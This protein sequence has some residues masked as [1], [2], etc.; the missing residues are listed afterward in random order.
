[1]YMY[2]NKKSKIIKKNQTK[3]KKIGEIKRIKVPMT[4]TK[5]LLINKMMTELLRRTLKQIE[6]VITKKLKHTQISP[7]A[8]EIEVVVKSVVLVALQNLN[9]PSFQ[10]MNYH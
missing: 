2:I 1:M 8:L 9:L 4:T 6:K 5:H 10:L 3:I 7:R